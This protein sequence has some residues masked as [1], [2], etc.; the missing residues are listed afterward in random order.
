M[1][2]LN[3]PDPDNPDLGGVDILPS[4]AYAV[5][6]TST[7][8][9]LVPTQFQQG[10]VNQ[11]NGFFTAAV[12]YT[13]TGKMAMS[14]N[15]TSAL[16]TEGLGG[17]NIGGATIRQLYGALVF[18]RYNDWNTGIVISNQP[19]VS[20]GSNADVTLTLYGE[21]GTVMGSF[22]DQIGGLS[23]RVYYLP[24][25]PIQ[26]PDGFRG[27]AVVS[28]VNPVATF[29]TIQ[30]GSNARVSAGAHHVNYE[31][32]QAISFNFYRQEALPLSASAA[33]GGTGTG[34]AQFVNPCYLTAGTTAGS[35]QP[36]QLPAGSLPLPGGLVNTNPLTFGAVP[37]CLAAPAV[38]RQVAS[39]P[40]TRSEVPSGPTTGLRLFNPDVSRT[41]LS[42]FASV[43]YLDPSGVVQGNSITTVTIPALGSATIFLGA[44][45]RLPDYFTGT[46][47]IL[48]D[49]PII[50][51]AN[52]VDYGVRTRD[53][54]WA[55]NLPN[56]R[57]FT[58]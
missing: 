6:V 48:S 17:A 58:S 31:R 2:N 28:F 32:N 57:G 29:P 56:Q 9:L 35:V 24:T 51:I 26:L 7:G 30:S 13:V 40:V 34:E 22:T 19:V 1:I 5:N 49:Q 8:G 45:A 39:D 23:A 44:D 15:G 46:A 16:D 43:T 10:G 37:N 4:G 11:P 12:S 55:Y 33:A 47:I 25:L 18:K 20:G 42:A 21:D 27:T 38:E 14:S 41:G 54:S 50:G 36:I 52:V 53:G 3:A